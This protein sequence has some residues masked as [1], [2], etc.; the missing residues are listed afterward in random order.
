VDYGT[1]V[2]AEVANAPLGEYNSV[3]EIEANYDW[4]SPDHWDYSHLPEAI[5]GHEHQPI[6][7][8]G[9]EPFLLYK[10]LRGEIQAFIDLVE[11]PR[12]CIT[13]WTSSLSWHISRLSAS[14]RPSG[15]GDADLR[16]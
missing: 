15:D 8:G 2:Y 4:P 16:S 11:N 7:G 13:A 12:S 5:K 10:H 14:S 9:S 1:G 6:R 3:E